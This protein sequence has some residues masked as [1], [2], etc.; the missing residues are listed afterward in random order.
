MS[1]WCVM[2]EFRI[3]MYKYVYVFSCFVFGL[4]HLDIAL[5]API[6]TAADSNHKYFFIVFERK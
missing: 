2:S 1:A 5:K 4:Y 3:C 6:T